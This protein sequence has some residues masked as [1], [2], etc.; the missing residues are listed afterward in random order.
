MEPVEWMH[1]LAPAAAPLHETKAPTIE[2]RRVSSFSS[3]TFLD[4]MF[5]HQ[6]RRQPDAVAVR[7]EDRHLTYGELDAKATA[8]ARRLTQ[9]GVAPGT[10]V[11]LCFERSIAMIV[12]MLGVLKAGGAYLP[13]DPAYPAERLAFILDDAKPMLVLAGL[14]L[15][16]RIPDG[17]APVMV[18]DASETTDTAF[19][20]SP[21]PQSRSADDL[22]YIIYTSGSTGTPKGVMVTHRN[23]TRLLTATDPWFGF[24]AA[25]VWTLFH[26]YAFDFSVWEIWGCL[27]SGG[28]LVVVP[29]VV[30][31][32][33][34]DFRTLLAREQVTVLNQT[35][36]AFYQLM[37][38]DESDTGQPLT[39]RTV[40]F[41]GEALNFAKLRPWFAK[42]GDSKPRLINMYGITETTVHVSYRPVSAAD[43]TNETRSLIGEPIPDLDIHILDERQQTLPVG[44]AGEICVGGAGVARGY[45]NRPELSAERF[46]TDPF[47]GGGAR[48]YRSGDIARRLANG[49]IEYLGRRDNQ[50]KI[51][52]FRIEL[53]EIETAAT[54][55]PDL[56]DC[57]VIVDSDHRLICYFTAKAGTDLHIS[58]IRNFLRQQLPSHMVPQGYLRLDAMPLT[59]NGKLDRDALPKPSFGEAESPLRVE[60]ANDLERLIAGIWQA[61]LKAD[62]IGVSENFFDIGGDSVLLAQVHARLRRELNRDISMVDL[63]A[64]TT[65]RS[66]A[67]HLGTG[68]PNMREPTAAQQQAQRQRVAFRRF[69]EHHNSNPA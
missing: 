25:D 37:Q 67:G 50:V 46:I 24:D 47:R 65:V 8:L 53:G 69:R 63:F 21:L 62:R 54:Q 27:L 40:I 45:L 41:G 34:H 39:L 57:A 59:V 49:D 30:S 56:R 17:P 31:R 66:L 6:V 28:R 19:T 35:P 42:Y 2:Q 11:A 12:A 14:S 29:Q 43:A 18:V 10:L 58:D 61:V 16:A 26:S 55:H 7:F 13:L 4:A 9:S 64:F 68:A 44:V 51:H 22:A 60:A 48:L 20:A 52:G 23:V 38:A 1:E 3:D 15:R 33:P 5:A 32:S 36:T